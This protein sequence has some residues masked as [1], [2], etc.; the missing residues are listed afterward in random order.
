MKNAT[1]NYNASKE[2]VSLQRDDGLSDVG[3]SRE[4]GVSSH[5]QTQT[6]LDAVEPLEPLKPSEL[7]ESLE[8]VEPPNLHKQHR[9]VQN[10]A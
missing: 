5:T 10:G 2:H 1:L 9:N 7:S 4:T 8:P 6:P 3:M